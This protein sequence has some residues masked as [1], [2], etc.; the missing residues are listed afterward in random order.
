VNRLGEPALPDHIG[1]G[2]PMHY[3]HRAVYFILRLVY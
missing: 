3:P 2:W 1:P